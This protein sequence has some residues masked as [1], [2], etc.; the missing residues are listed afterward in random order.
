MTRT[1]FMIGLHTEVLNLSLFTIIVSFKSYSRMGFMLRGS[2]CSLPELQNI[3]Y[4]LVIDILV[5][6]TQLLKSQISHRKI[7]NFIS[8]LDNF[9]EW[10]D[11]ATS[12]PMASILHSFRLHIFLYLLRYL[13]RDQ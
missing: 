3:V 13:S 6:R 4:F 7:P 1:D 10:K 8:N 5:Y 11:I 2:D 12:L 9:V